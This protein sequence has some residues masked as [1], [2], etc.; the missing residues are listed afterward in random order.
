MAKRNST[1]SKAR[2]PKFI[3]IEGHQLTEAMYADYLRYVESRHLRNN[4]CDAKSLGLDDFLAGYRPSRKVKVQLLEIYQTVSRVGL[5]V[6][7]MSDYPFFAAPSVRPAG[8]ELLKKL[9]LD[10]YYA[11]A[12]FTAIA[13]DVEAESKS[14]IQDWLAQAK[15]LE[16]MGCS[17]DFAHGRA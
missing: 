10:L 1:R 15:R 17:Q 8:C 5:A 13:G 4:D 16:Q 6:A 2:K 11:S 12:K 9:A 7:S 14:K 3:A